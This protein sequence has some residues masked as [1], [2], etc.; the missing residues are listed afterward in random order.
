METWH[1]VLSTLHTVNAA[2]TITRIIDVFPPHQQ[3]QIAVQLSLTLELIISQRLLPTADWKWRVAAREILYNTSAVAN[4]IRQRKIPQIVSIMETWMKYWMTTMD[5]SLA[6]LVAKGIITLE[7]ALPKVKNI[8]TFKMLINSL[9]N[10]R[11]IF[12]PIE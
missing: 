6:E 8:E 3:E 5:R 1:L 4:N 12:K 10:G 9:Q 7:E 11:K 2:Q